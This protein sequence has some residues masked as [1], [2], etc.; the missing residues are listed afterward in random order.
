M[1][2]NYLDMRSFTGW[3][4]K[5]LLLGVLWQ[6][7]LFACYLFVARTS[8]TNPG[9]YI[10]FALFSLGLII[11]LILGAKNISWGYLIGFTVLLSLGFSS[12][13]VVMA[14][15]L[16]PAFLKDVPFGSLY[17]FSEM[18]PISAIIAGIYCAIGIFFKLLFLLHQ[19]YG[20]HRTTN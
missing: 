18:G 7:A 14:Y 5:L 20:Y 9:R 6:W 16:F 11:V 2:R 8:F 1:H 12:F 3:F 13:Y 4:W 17:F 19:K 15:T 10:C